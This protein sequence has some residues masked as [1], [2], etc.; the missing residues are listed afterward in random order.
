LHQQ[1]AETRGPQCNLSVFS[2]YEE[3]LYLT[4]F[5]GFYFLMFTKQEAPRNKK[6]YFLINFSD[7]FS[8]CAWWNS[9][10]IVMSTFFVWLLLFTRY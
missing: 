1:T 8:L 2:L 7:F 3:R 6:I 10:Y 4:N 5:G 9:V